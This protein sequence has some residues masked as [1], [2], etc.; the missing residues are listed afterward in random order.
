MVDF[1]L[2]IESFIFISVFSLI[3]IIPCVLVVIIGKKAI[4]DMG[5]Y[6]TKISLIQMSI[7]LKLVVIEIS[8]FTAL[9]TFLRVFE[10]RT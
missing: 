4:E 10:H 2:W 5:R 7:F 9:L 8:T 1:N 3:I 6:P